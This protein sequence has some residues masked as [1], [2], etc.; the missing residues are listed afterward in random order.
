MGTDE[1]LQKGVIAPII[2]PNR[3]PL[4]P[5]VL[6]NTFT[7]FSGFN[8]NLMVEVMVVIPKIK[9]GSKIISCK[10]NGKSIV[11]SIRLFIA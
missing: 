6:F 2:L 8:P 10:K 5:L 4:K 11:S 1:Q 3:Y 9:I 7:I